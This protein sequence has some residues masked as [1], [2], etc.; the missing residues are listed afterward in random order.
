MRAGLST[1]R[2]FLDA[3]SPER[4]EW[5]ERGGVWNKL[6]ESFAG[7]L[8]GDFIR[9]KLHSSPKPFIDCQQT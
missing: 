5:R 9:A 3:R 2:R 4:E 8:R 1:L 6:P 7:A